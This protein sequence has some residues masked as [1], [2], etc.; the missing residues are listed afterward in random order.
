MRCIIDAQLPVLLVSILSGL[1][2]HAEHVEELPK[3]DESS[4]IDI[5]QYAD[6]NNLIVITKDTDFFYSHTLLGKPRKLLLIT[7]GNI[8]NK[9]LFDLIRT[10]YQTL[11]LLFETCNFIEFNNEGIIAH[12]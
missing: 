10:N 5:Y 4:D 12:D 1:G 9:E 2:I 6:K 8:K 11:Y 3:G 7:T